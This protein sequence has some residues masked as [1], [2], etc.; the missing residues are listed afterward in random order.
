MN[1][2][3]TFLL[4]LAIPFSVMADGP[5]DVEFTM[6]STSEIFINGQ[7]FNSLSDYVASDLFRQLGMRC[8]TRLEAITPLDNNVMT[9]DYDDCSLSRTA[10]KPEYSGPQVLEI[11]V[12]FHV[13]IKTDGTGNLTDKQ[14]QDQINVLNEDFRAMEGT[15]GAAGFDTRIQFRLEGVT[16][17]W[18]DDW[19]LDNNELDYKKTLGQDPAR[20]LNVYTN[21]ASGY[22]GYATFPQLSAGQD[23]D[24]VVILYETVGGR[25]N[26]FSQYDQGRT[27]VHEVGHYL[28][29]LHTFEQVGINCGNTYDSGDLIVDTPAEQFPHFSCVQ[30][31]TCLSPDPIHN[32]MS[33]TP[34]ICWEEFTQEQANRM[35]CTLLNYR[36]ALFS[37]AEIPTLSQQGM[38]IFS[39]LIILAT[40]FVLK[41]RKTNFTVS[42]K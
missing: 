31:I 7:T 11:P 22:L 41:T 27:L 12:Y 38:I 30:T 10:V 18:N 33:Y 15:V 25:N 21:N 8:G 32:Y 34:D 16:R 37:I 14:I 24:G 23:I 13:L 2:I 20:Y 17:T 6:N 39:V 4:I 28:G 36:P 42:E 29:L 3:V 40:A 19:F 26:G 35:R 5:T 1:L 9:G